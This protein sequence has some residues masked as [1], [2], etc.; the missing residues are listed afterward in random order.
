MAAAIFC[1]GMV[2][3]H[4]CRSEIVRMASSSSRRRVSSS[5]KEDVARRNGVR[6]YRF[7]SRSRRSKN[8]NKESDSG[9]L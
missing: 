1:L 3:R 6:H 7:E 2:W 9:E 5:S 8:D 4:W